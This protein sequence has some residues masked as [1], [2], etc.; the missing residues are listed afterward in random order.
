MLNTTPETSSCK[1][2]GYIPSILWNPKVHY[3]IHKNSP[4]VPIL[5]QSN[6]VHTTPPYPSNIHP[7]IIYPPKPWSS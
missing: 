7:N 5:S 2:T 4:L 1:A 6:P 3:C